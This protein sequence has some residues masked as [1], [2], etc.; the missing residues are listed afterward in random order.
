[1]SISRRTMLKQ[2]AVAASAATVGI[3]QVASASE[4]TP[5][6]PTAQ[7]TFA[8]LKS[9]AKKKI[10]IIFDTDIG[11]D[12]DD[13]WALVMLLKCPELDVKLVASDGGNATYRARLAAKLLEVCGRSDIPVAVGVPPGDNRGHQSDWIGD[14][15]LDKYAGAVHEDG[16]GAIIRAIKQSAE[17]LTVCCIGAVPNI[18]AALKRDPSI[19]ENARFVG[20]HGSIRIGYDG[21]STP[22]REANVVKGI[23]ALRD[24]FAAPWECTITPLD[25]C[26]LV[27]LSGAK[28]AKIRQRIEEDPAIKAL[29]ENYRVWLPHPP[30]LKKRP[31][32]SKRSTTL[33][34]LVAVYLAFAEDLVQI[35][36]LP[37][38]VTDRGMTVI[39]RSKRTIRCATKWNDMSDFE[40]LLVERFVQN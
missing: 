21:A 31:D 37:I 5:K 27:K 24:V 10:P 35:E 16:V 19:V 15:T 17:P 26:G 25:T 6:F 34:D 36:N 32:P 30:W 22:S 38:G 11:G 33:F 40:D 39:D 12:I 3:P 18:A 2:T 29:M 8:L 13:T 20:M 23:A 28:Y 9:G 1:M 14:Y 4:S 7:D